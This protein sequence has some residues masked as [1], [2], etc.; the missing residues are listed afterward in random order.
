MCSP[1]FLHL[2]RASVLSRGVKFKV[3]SYAQDSQHLA[4]MQT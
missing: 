2:Y 3:F 1:N 4:G